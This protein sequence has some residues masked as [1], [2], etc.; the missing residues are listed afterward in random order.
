MRDL[1]GQTTLI[2]LRKWWAGQGLFCGQMYFFPSTMGSSCH[3]CSIAKLFG[4]T[5]WGKNVTTGKT[6]LKYQKRFAGKIAGKNGIYHADPL[7][8]KYGILKIDDLY[9]QQLRVHAWQFWNKQL[10]QSQSVM[11][12]K[13]SDMHNYNTRAAETL[14]SATTK[15]QQ[16]KS[17]RVSKE[18]SLVPVKLRECMTCSSFRRQSRK[19]LLQQYR[20]FECNQIGCLACL[21]SRGGRDGNALASQGGHSTA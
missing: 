17:Y 6:L 5:S 8:A 18:W 15:D 11:L 20:R 1:N 7:F 12:Q 10:P 2:K 13:V 19:N 9:K 16:S 21:G 4:G 3:I 14:L